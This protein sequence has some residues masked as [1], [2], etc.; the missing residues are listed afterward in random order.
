MRSRLLRTAGLTICTA[1]ALTVT[2]S[3]GGLALGREPR[4]DEYFADPVSEPVK[5]A[6]ATAPAG[7]QRSQPDGPKPDSHSSSE[8]AGRSRSPQ[9]PAPIGRIEI[10]RVKVSGIVREGAD[11]HILAL[12]VGHVTGTALPGTSGNSAFAAH[13]DKEF[14]GLRQ[15]RNGD[16]ILVET[17]NGEF[18]YV[19]DSLRV[20]LPTEVSVLNPTSE[21]TITLITC[22]PFDYPGEAPERLI[23]KGHR[24]TSEALITKPVERTH[25]AGA[26]N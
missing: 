15:I 16:E 4:A 22:Y 1:G 7:N 25:N 17:S 11:D 6:R 18:R 23:V 10:P 13:R 5:E 12:G 8:K 3:G 21:P 20:V 9:V 2:W 26:S 24:V 14:R 19:V